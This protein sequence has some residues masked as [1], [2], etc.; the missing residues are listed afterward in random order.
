MTMRAFHSGGVAEDADTT[1]GRTRV[2]ELFEARSPKTP[3]SLSDITGIAKVSIHQG[4]TTVEITGEEGSESSYP[5]PPAF[6][7]VV[8]VG[9]AVKERLV[10]ARSSQDKSTLR[11]TVPG[12]VHSI[13]NNTIIIKHTEAQK[14]SYEISA[15]ESLLIK[16]GQ[17]IEAG[18]PL[19]AGHFNLQE[20]LIK[21]GMAAV[22]HYI[23]S[24]VQSIY[25]SQG[26]TI[27]DKHL[28]IITRKM[29]SKLRILASGYTPLLV[30]DVVDV[31]TLQT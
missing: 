18:E 25:A 31:S 19:N 2:E 8:K 14:L 9:E 5:L 28:E 27:N 1:Q 21:K 26:Q 13:A 23:I 7:P 15:S 12:V 29:F 16:S 22:Q 17:R 6:E 4:K 30:A 24:E 11:S 20:L 10:L 3:A